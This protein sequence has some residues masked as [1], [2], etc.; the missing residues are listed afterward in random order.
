MLIG[1]IGDMLS[2]AEYFLMPNA[3]NVVFQDEGSYAIYQA[4]PKNASF[5]ER[6]VVVDK[7]N[8]YYFENV[9]PIPIIRTGYCYAWNSD[10][11]SP[12]PHP[13]SLRPFYF[14]YIRHAQP[15]NTFRLFSPWPG[16]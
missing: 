13:P 4:M 7:L 2:K 9:G 10:K 8:Q 15:I 5:E 11:I 6:S 12:W 14:D 16:R 3:M 1:P